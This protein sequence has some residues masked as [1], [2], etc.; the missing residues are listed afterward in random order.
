PSLE[1]HLGRGGT[2]TRAEEGFRAQHLA[3]STAIAG[4]ASFAT[5]LPLRANG[6]VHVARADRHDVFVDVSSE[7]EAVSGEAVEGA[8]VYPG[9]APETDVVQIVESTR[10]E[11]LR[12]LHGPRAGRSFTW[13]L[14]PGPAIT[15]LR[16]REGR[17]EAL[18]GDAI[19]IVSEPIVA[20]DSKGVR[21]EAKVTLTKNDGSYRL[22][23]ELSLDGLAFPVALDPGWTITFGHLSQVHDSFQA[24]RLNDGRVAALPGAVAATLKVDIYDPVTDKFSLGPPVSYSRYNS[25]AI[26]L[27]SSNKIL[28]VGGNYGPYNANY[29]VWDAT[30]GTAGT[31][32]LPF[33]MNTPVLTVLPS[34]KIFATTDGT[35][36]AIYNPAADAWTATTPNPRSH[37]GPSIVTLASGKVLVAGGCCSQFIAEIYD[38]TSDTWTP[39][40]NMNGARAGHKMY[41]LPSGKILVV[42]NDTGTGRGEI[43]DEVANTWTKITDMPVDPW[44]F[45]GAQLPSG[46]VLLA[47]VSSTWKQTMLYDEATGWSMSTPL[48]TRRDS[49]QVVALLDGRA[50]AIA[51][52]NGT[53]G[54]EDS[55]YNAELWSPT[56]KTCSV[57]GDCASGFCVD[58]YCCDRACT[59]QCNACDAPGRE[60][61]CMPLTGSPPHGSRTSCSPYLNCYDGK[62]TSGCTSVSD[63]T[64]GNGCIYGTCAVK[65]SAGTACFDGTDCSTGNC[66]DGVCCDTTCT[67]QC[68]ACDVKG[69]VGTCTDVSDAPHGSRTSCA[70][71]VCGGGT[72]RAGCTADSQCSTGNYCD[73]TGKCVPALN[74]GKACT[75]GTQCTSGFCVDGYCC[76]TACTGACQ[77]CSKTPGTCQ[78]VTAG[79]I[80][81]R[82]ICVGECV[83]GC[84][85]TG[86]GYQP[87]TTVCGVSCIGNKLTN[88]GRCAGTSEACSGSS[89]APCAG[90]LVCADGKTCKT[91]CTTAA[92]CVSGICDTASGTCGAA[93]VDAGSETSTDAGTDSG[94]DATTDGATSDTFVDDTSIAMD[95][96]ADSSVFDT[97][98][99]DGSTTADTRE[100]AET[101]APQIDPKSA[102]PVSVQT[103]AKDADC[104][105]GFCV[106]GVCCDSR[107]DQP[108]H[109]CA[110]LSSPG[111][112]TEEPIGVDLKQD[113]GPAFTCLGTCG[114]GGECIGAGKGS[115]CARNR[116][117]GPSAGVGPAFCSAPGARC[118]ESTVVPFECSP[119]VCAP[120]FGACLTGCST[121]LDC[122]QGFICDL[123]SKSCIAP[124]PAEDSGG[125]AINQPGRARALPLL[126]IARA[127]VGARRRRSRTKSRVIDRRA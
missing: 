112:C 13:S 63:C 36:A 89:S 11:E 107:C 124:P 94:T 9:A 33:V 43:Y 127:L 91:T 71:Y 82:G 116:C 12:V 21:R 1:N 60:G 80:D 98:P 40:P 68:K 52:T 61:Y 96:G 69:S 84:G 100:I 77:T 16:L 51:G 23:A 120:A 48:N 41:K 10:V 28:I 115:M 30:T 105:S 95:G 2:L 109:S 45:G 50:I 81:P 122:A 121:S 113:C 29:E 38:P 106:E 5:T 20:I 92:D 117:T 85:A 34:G 86:C 56:A 102:L 76:G 32:P 15:E 110:L 88:G 90:G 35:Q 49:P 75:A 6:A 58:G 65:L 118:D 79:T 55:R 24:V 126:A 42:G 57:P 114:T 83:T 53:V 59:E 19:R 74:N 101:P 4:G 44:A 108:C 67:S 119:Y 54:T 64:A 25:A 47:N 78:N 93:P 17:V 72:C 39:I 14:R 37:G 46:K 27:G 18:E 99:S 62:C 31:K 123:G 97:T 26:R 103:C 8:V 111:K 3:P 66:V 87:N 7:V 125:C 70:P 73:G 22:S 104:A